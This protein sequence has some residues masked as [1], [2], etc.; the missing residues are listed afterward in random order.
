MRDWNFLGIIFCLVFFGILIIVRV[1]NQSLMNELHRDGIQQTQSVQSPQKAE[2]VFK[3]LKTPS[4][5]PSPFESIDS[6]KQISSPAEE[7][8]K[9]DTEKNGIK[10]IYE[11]PLQD[12]ILVQ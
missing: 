10:A 8:R 7:D 2:A 3:G 11:P 9:T 6:E 12:V 1:F 5:K 4:L